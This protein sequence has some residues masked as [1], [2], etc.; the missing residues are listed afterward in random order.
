MEEHLFGKSKAELETI[1]KTAIDTV[2]VPTNQVVQTS[3]DQIRR[4]GW[5]TEDTNPIHQF[6]DVAQAKGLSKTPVMGAHLAA[7]GEQY[8][9]KIVDNLSIPGLEIIGQDTKFKGFVYPDEKLVFKINKSNIRN[10]FIQLSI[11]GS[12]TREDKTVDALDITVRIGD[13]YP[14]M[15]QIAGP[16]FW[17]KYLIIPQKVQEFH[18]CVGQIG[19]GD[20][21][22]SF[23]TSFV[24]STLIA[25]LKEQTFTME[26]FN[27]AMNFDYMRK[28]EV[29]NDPIKVD[30]FQFREPREINSGE[31]KNYLYTGLR[32]VCSQATK[33][34]AYGTVSVMTPFPNLR[35]Q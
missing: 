21:P 32:I 12:V 2:Q 5:I 1:L 13:K 8:A 31:S 33:P 16:G 17:R 30:L 24:P 23:I 27:G 35:V 6:D 3:L 4:F 18:R 22:N 7:H 29:G 11:N 28:A 19:N 10:D 34:L 14:L 26:G 15:P 25:L 20:I 9:V